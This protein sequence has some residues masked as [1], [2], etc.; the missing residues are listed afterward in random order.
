MLRFH[1]LIPPCVPFSPAKDKLVICGLEDK[2]WSNT[3]AVELTCKSSEKGVH[4]MVGFTR[5]K[6]KNVVG[7]VVEYKYQVLP[8]NNQPWYED[9]KPQVKS[10]SFIKYNELAH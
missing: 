8:H 6:R 3:K 9:I 10:S 2:T 4:Q 5:L 7:K 1:V